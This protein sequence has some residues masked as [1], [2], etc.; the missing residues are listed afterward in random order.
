MIVG[1]LIGVAVSEF[2]VERAI[3]AAYSNRDDPLFGKMNAP[4]RSTY[5]YAGLGIGAATG[6][7]FGAGIGLRGSSNLNRAIDKPLRE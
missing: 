2:V 4:T 7:L 6:A 1:L 5:R 3:V